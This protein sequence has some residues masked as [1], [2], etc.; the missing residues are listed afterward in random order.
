MM[1]QKLLHRVEVGGATNPSVVPSRIMMEVGEATSS[2]L[3]V[4]GATKM[5]SSNNIR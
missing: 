5:N 3:K 4:R 2:M 1:R